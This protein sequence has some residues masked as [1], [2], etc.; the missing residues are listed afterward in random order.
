MAGGDFDLHVVGAGPAGSFAAHAAASSGAKVI[1]SEDHFAI[2]APVHCSGLVSSSALEQMSGVV[3]YKKIIH[4]RIRRANLHGEGKTVSLTFRSP[5]AY[6]I[7]RGEFDRLAALSAQD[8]G[9]TYEL[10]RRITSVSDL[11]SHSIV[12]ADGPDSTVARIF[13]FPRIKSFACAWQGD[14][15]YKSPDLSA[16]EVFFDPSFAPGFIGW[17]IPIDEER[18]KIGLGVSLPRSVKAAKEKFLSRLG[19]DENLCENKFSALIP[20]SLRQKTYAASGK[21]HVCLAGDAAGQVKASS[22]GGIFF[23]AMCG[24]LAG[25]NFRHMENYEAIWREKYGADLALHRLLRKG[26]DSLSPPLV[27]AWLATIKGLRL[28]FVLTEVGEMDEYSKM[29]ASKTL[30]SLFKAWAK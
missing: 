18:A 30:V 12:G 8:A 14:F 5:K 26:L 3:D 7:D 29:A 10:G 13:G 24:K 19:L 28:D 22:G 23:G 4:N 11:R 27:D 1:V 16:V 25:E 6:L 15:K 21:F 2:G 17:I 20:I 9:A